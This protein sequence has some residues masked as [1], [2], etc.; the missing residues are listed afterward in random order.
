MKIIKTIC[1]IL[2]VTLMIIL[3][4]N[5]IIEASSID[6]NISIGSTN[7]INSSKEYTKKIL[8]VIQNIGT[9]IS[10]VALCIIG[11][12]YMV[13][14]VEE[15]AELKGVIIYYIIGAV[16]VFATTNILS[17]AYNVISDLNL[18]TTTTQTHTSSSGETH[19]GSGGKF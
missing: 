8:Q 12:R 7:A 2:L 3:I 4:Y 9:V 17:I 11:I 13:S 19:G 15:K 16:L 10:V 14:S 1:R 6:T 18:D 5:I